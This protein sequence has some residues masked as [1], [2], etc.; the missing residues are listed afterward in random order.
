MERATSSALFPRSGKGFPKRR[1]WYRTSRS[2]SCWLTRRS[3]SICRR[4]GH[5]EKHTHV[6][7]RRVSH[8]R[9]RYNSYRNRVGVARLRR[10]YMC[11]H[12]EQLKAETGEQFRNET[13]F[14][15]PCPSPHPSTN[16]HFFNPKRYFIQLEMLLVL[17]TPYTPP[18]LPT[19]PTPFTSGSGSSPWGS[20]RG[21]R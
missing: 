5:M 7:A 3:T 15:T 8:R 20:G 4:V 12:G 9:H 2:K 18:R 21:R 13:A 14:T 10:K 6:G 1:T 11:T 16:I 17:N 19:H